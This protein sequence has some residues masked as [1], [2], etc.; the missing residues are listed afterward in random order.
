MESREGVSLYLLV[1]AALSCEGSGVTA[2][3]TSAFLVQCLGW[4]SHPMSMGWVRKKEGT[5]NDSS[6]LGAC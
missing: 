5:G 3:G 4:S 2:T 6:S 1:C